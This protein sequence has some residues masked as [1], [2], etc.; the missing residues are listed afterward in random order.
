M[1]SSFLTKRAR[2]P[3]SK[4]AE[5]VHGSA[6][7]CVRVRVCVCVCVCVC[8]RMCAY[9]CVC[10]CVRVCVCVFVCVY[11]FNELSLTFFDEVDD[12]LLIHVYGH[13][14]RYL[15]NTLPTLSVAVTAIVCT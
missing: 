14:E 6:F 3:R 4:N 5:C 13:V 8:V 7:A 15:S 10:M 11:V 1:I 9:V 2:T 12:C